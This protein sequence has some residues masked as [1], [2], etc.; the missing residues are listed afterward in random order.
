M[1]LK[2]YDGFETKL[3]A[4]K[5]AKQLKTDKKYPVQFVRVKKGTSKR[6]KWIV[7]IGGKNSQIW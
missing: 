6:L 5:T 3:A 7:Y 4:M 2:P 1:A